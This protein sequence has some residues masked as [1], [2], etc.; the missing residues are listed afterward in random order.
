MARAKKQENKKIEKPVWLTYTEEEVKAIILKLSEKGLTAEKIG[1]V[2]RDQY[3]IPKV[4][5]YNLKISKVLKEKDKYIDPD[6]KNLD[7]KL[8]KV[9]THYKKNKQDKRAERSLIITK[10]RSKK[11]EDYQKKRENGGKSD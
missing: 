8:E 6:I 7:K 2:L 11:R 9:I 10:S 3:G 1:L 4:K 5:I